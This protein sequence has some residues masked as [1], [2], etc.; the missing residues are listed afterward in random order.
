MT[1]RDPAAPAAPLA[2]LL[3]F[4]V[5]V[6]VGATHAACVTVTVSPPRVNVA[7][8]AADVGLAATAYATTP[9]PVAV[10]AASPSA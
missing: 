7:L 4:T 2:T 3:G 6:H 1:A 5:V 8:R 10:A 9:E